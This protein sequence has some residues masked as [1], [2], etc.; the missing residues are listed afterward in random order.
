M[1][2]CYSKLQFD[3]QL[4][5]CRAAKSSIILLSVWFQFGR[6]LQHILSQSPYSDLHGTRFLEFDAEGIVPDLFGLICHNP[7][8]LKSLSRHVDTGE[9]LSDAKIHEVL[10]CTICRFRYHKLLLCAESLLVCVI[11]DTCTFSSIQLCMQQ[12]SC[13]SLFLLCFVVD[14][15]AECFQL[16]GTCEQSQFLRK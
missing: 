6:L 2:L 7:S 11:R 3:T 10:S 14:A 16:C 15:R 5:Y 9:P 4:H 13:T 12:V 1:V 8:V